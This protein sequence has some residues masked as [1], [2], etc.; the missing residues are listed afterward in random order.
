MQFKRSFNIDRV[1]ICIPLS[2][3][4]LLEHAQAF[5]NLYYSSWQL[6]ESIDGPCEIRRRLVRYRFGFWDLRHNDGLLLGLYILSCW[7]YDFILLLSELEVLGIVL[8]FAITHL[9]ILATFYPISDTIHNYW[10]INSYHNTSLILDF[11]SQ[12]QYI[13][14][15]KIINYYQIRRTCRDDLILNLLD[16]STLL[17]PRVFLSIRSKSIR[18][19][20]FLGVSII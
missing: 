10:S 17:A 3:I 9:Y 8:T 2:L 12:Y 5:I 6:W 15:L 18:F 16:G 1:K 19:R 13:R 7:H 11:L 20:R 14:L 4:S